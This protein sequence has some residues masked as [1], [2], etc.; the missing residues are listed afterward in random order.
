[1]CKLSE[2]RLTGT[3]AAD[4]SLTVT[5]TRSV[6]GVLYA[7]EWIDGTFDNN[8]TF[9]LSCTD[10]PS[11]ADQTLLAISA[12]SADNDEFFYP[13]D[14][15]VSLAG[16]SAVYTNDNKPLRI[17][18]PLVSGRLKLVVAA[19]GNAKTGGCIAYVREMSG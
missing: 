14:A 18:E 7:V 16:A 2:I 6:L 13:R 10:S 8:V 12:G 19:G 15:I 17:I 1:M 4:G 11:G 5:A 9:T 3:T